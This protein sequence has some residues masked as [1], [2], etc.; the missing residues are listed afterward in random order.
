[1]NGTMKPDQKIKVSVD[2]IDAATGKEMKSIATTKQDWKY[3]VQG[4]W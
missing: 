1:M 4:K 3:R 2:R